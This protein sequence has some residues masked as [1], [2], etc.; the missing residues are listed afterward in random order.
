MSNP[1]RPARKVTTIN[2]TK[3]TTHVQL[4]AYVVPEVDAYMDFLEAENK[5]LVDELQLVI[6]PQEV[7][8]G[9]GGLSKSQAKRLDVQRG[10]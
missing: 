9:V 3:D 2:T 5:R 7:G 1:T 4:Y 8:G 6:A 10:E